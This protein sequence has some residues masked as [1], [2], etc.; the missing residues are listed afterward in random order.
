[1]NRFRLMLN[2]LKYFW[3]SHVGVTLG[4]VVSTIVLTGALMV[5]DC[6]DFTL[7]SIALK[8]LGTIQFALSHPSRFFRGQL[9]D[10]LEQ[11]LAAQVA[12]VFQV[13]GVLRKGGE[14]FSANNV[15]VYGVDSRFWNFGNKAFA[16]FDDGDESVIINRYLA[17]R[18]SIREGDDIVLRIEN[19]STLSKEVP[20]STLDDFSMAFRLPVKKIVDND[21]MGRF[22]FRSNQVAPYNVFVPIKLIQE[23]TAKTNL[24][25]GLL[26][27]AK[28]DHDVLLEQINAALQ[29]SWNLQDAQIEIKNLNSNGW[30]EIRTDRVFLESTVSDGLTRGISSGAA[31]GRAFGVLT[32]FVQEIQFKDRAAP[33]S[34]VAAIDA[35]KAG[36]TLFPSLQ[37]LQDNEIILN[38]WLA[39]DL[40]VQK[41]DELTLVYNVLGP[42]RKLIERKRSFM[43]RDIVAM[44]DPLNDPS[45]MPDFPG[46]TKSEHCREW[47]PGFTIDLDKIR[48]KD[49]DYWDQYKGTPKAFISL[50]T[51]QEMW[52]NRFG[53]LTAIRF[54]HSVAPD[55]LIEK[56]IAAFLQP[57]TMGFDFIPV[58][59]LALRAVNQAMSFGPLFI[60]LSFF[61][62]VSALILTS[63]LFLFGLEQRASHTGLLF[64]LG[65]SK[66]LIRKLYFYEVIV[67]TVLGGAIGV[68]LAA[69]YSQG[70]IWAL[71][72]IWKDAVAGIE[73]ETTISPAT[74]IYGFLASVIT[75]ILVIWIGIRRQSRLPIPSLLTAKA[76]SIIVNQ[77][78]SN[79]GIWIASAS[80]TGAILLYFFSSQNS[81]AAATGTFFGIGALLLITG[82]GLSHACFFRFMMQQD[83]ANLSLKSLGIR[84]TGRRRGRS[85]AVVGLLA[86]GAFL[87]I[88]VGANRQDAWLDA[89]LVN[90]GTGGF[91]YYSETTLPLIHDLN[92]EAGC[93]EFGLSLSDLPGLRVYPLRFREGDDASCLNMNRAQNPKLL[94]VDPRLFSSRKAFSFVS[95]VDG[96]TSPQQ[97]WKLLDRKFDDGSIPAI[98]DQSTAMW[99]LGKSIGDTLTYK[100][101]SGASFQIRLVGFLANSIFQGAVLIS[102]QNCVQKYPSVSGYRVLLM[103][104]PKPFRSEYRG[105]LMNSLQDLG[106]EMTPC[107]ERLAA[108]FAIQNAY[109]SI[110]QILGGLG[111]IL[112]SIGVGVVVMRNILDR[113]S[114]FA[115][116]RALGFSHSSIRWMIVT[117]HAFLL[118]LGLGCATLSGITASLPALRFH[119]STFPFLSLTLTLILIL[120]SGLFWIYL[121][122]LIALRENLL[123][124]LR[125]E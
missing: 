6:V 82:L 34:M 125:S 79:R 19:P 121:S 117:E 120:L 17:D 89:E 20:L 58:R 88:A 96:D 68:W 31:P 103:D 1:M 56:D 51:G 37:G 46:I 8:R 24:C 74:M 84:N 111:L 66:A 94:G 57:S 108:F 45:L 39:Q 71:S 21:Q 12:P 113:R 123:T 70:M 47:D 99:A 72:T 54:Q 9:A 53:N 76:G 14:S 73:F 18:F 55:A 107:G 49:E 27:S 97:A 2:G 28:H 38:D 41:G 115:L 112:G 29:N 36:N 98:V 62:I 32:Y 83:G 33:Y 110:F 63:L 100:D 65:Y 116:M 11:S 109:L 43:V 124:S 59:E 5:G 81:V 105:I 114:E 90:S 26:V 75:T 91:A 64:A 7:R 15:F 95:T 101:E 122:T 93:N 102:D 60:S 104:I 42:M 35:S 4:V 50:Q 78:P 92:T 118:I 67:L 77:Q 52:A 48:D 85:L 16:G 87:V 86:S 40:Q 106:I 13:K 80:F 119:L 30:H 25:N 44:S 69:L 3:R 10:D 61:L 23:K 22:D